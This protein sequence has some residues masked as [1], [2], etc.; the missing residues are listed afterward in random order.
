MRLTL[1]LYD[2]NFG[3][4]SWIYNQS[5]LIRHQSWDLAQSTG[6]IARSLQCTVLHLQVAHQD[7]KRNQ[8]HESPPNLQQLCLQRA[9]PSLSTPSWRTCW[10]FICFKNSP[11]INQNNHREFH[12]SFNIPLLAKYAGIATVIFV[13]YKR[14]SIFVPL[15]QT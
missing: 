12:A 14:C 2:H 15:K 13:S 11:T 1:Y 7:W 3:Y 9:N 4:D 6:G 8:D 10:H 5:L